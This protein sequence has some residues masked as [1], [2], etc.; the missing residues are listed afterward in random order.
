MNEVLSN[1]VMSLQL[2]RAADF[3]S[4]IGDFWWAGRARCVGTFIALYLSQIFI[5]FRN[6]DCNRFVFKICSEW[7]KSSEILCLNSWIIDETIILWYSK[8]L[9]AR[10]AKPGIEKAF[11]KSQKVGS[12][13]SIDDKKVWRD[14]AHNELWWGI[15]VMLDLILHWNSANTRYNVSYSKGL[16]NP[17]VKM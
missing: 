3:S 4:K 1:L 12:I 8:N 17:K 15:W 10:T 9:W 13:Y 2:V 7:Y 11:K 16:D 14:I 6:F 5:F